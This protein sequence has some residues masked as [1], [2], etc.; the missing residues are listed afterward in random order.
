VQLKIEK[1]TNHLTL[2]LTHFTGFTLF[3]ILVA[4]FI[5]SLLITAVF[6]SFRSISDSATTL[7]RQDAYYR[8]G[9]SALYRI[10]WDM[11]SIFVCSHPN[12][13]PPTQN[14]PPDLYRVLGEKSASSGEEFSKLRF[15]SSEHLG[16]N[17]DTAEGI[18]QI[19]YYIRKKNAGGYELKRSDQLWPYKPIEENM[20][21][22]VL[23]EKVKKL[24]IKF[25]DGSGQTHDHWDSDAAEFENTTPRSIEIKLEIGD[26]AV[27]VFLN[28][29]VALPVFREK[30]ANG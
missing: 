16:I 11:N 10:V 20:N 9:S 24:Q 25:F 22:P 8:M 6:T 2:R 26:E 19:V 7:K 14:A 29:I 18:A 15:T 27:S 3:E 12:Y 13:K 1:E 5:F 21:D 23:C 30:K 28:T 17:G 4:I